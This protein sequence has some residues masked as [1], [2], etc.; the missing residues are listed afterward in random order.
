MVEKESLS[1]RSFFFFFFGPPGS[2][3]S[4]GR[5]LTH[6][7]HLN[8]VLDRVYPLDM[9]PQAL[10]AFLCFIIR[11]NVLH[12]RSNHL[13][14][15]TILHFCYIR[16]LCL[17]T[18]HQKYFGHLLRR[19]RKWLKIDIWWDGHANSLH[20]H[21]SLVCWWAVFCSVVA[22]TDLLGYQ[23]W[24]LSVGIHMIEYWIKVNFK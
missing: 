9:D 14:L 16:P 6:Q 10:I 8:V 13:T 20:R 4:C 17:F 21:I 11:Y 24:F 3:Y 23:W 1:R 22:H 7:A 12:L 18:W 5:P 15:Q 2:F 19:E